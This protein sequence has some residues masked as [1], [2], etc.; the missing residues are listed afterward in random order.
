M[1]PLELLERLRIPSAYCIPCP[2]FA[3]LSTL[4]W[5]INLCNK[6]STAMVAC[7]RSCSPPPLYNLHNHVPASPGHIELKFRM[8][9]IAS[10]STSMHVTLAVSF[11]SRWRKQD[12]LNY[13]IH[14]VM[15]NF[16]NKTWDLISSGGIYMVI[17]IFMQTHYSTFHLTFQRLNKICSRST[18]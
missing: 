14:V 15:I 4:L 8:P 18:D 1:E 5:V 2:F 17:K 3:T 7:N 9:C 12:E 10:R 11:S 6:W 16:C 13:I